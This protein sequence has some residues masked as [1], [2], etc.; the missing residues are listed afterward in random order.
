M[1]VRRIAALAGIASV[2]VA[3]L[4][5]ALSLM[6]AAAASASVSIVAN[7]TSGCTSAYCYQPASITINSG[8]SV[9]LTDNSIAPHTVTR[10][11]AAPGQSDA[12]CPAIGAAGN[13]GASN[14]KFNSPTL[15]ANGGTYSHTF[16]AVGSY[17][18]YCTIHGYSVMHATV[19]ANAAAATPGASP[20]AA[21]APA[22]A[23]PSLARAG[24]GPAARPPGIWLPSVAAA[25]VL[26]GL[27]TML[28]SAVA[29]KRRRR[30]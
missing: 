10:C 12:G 15:S 20:S 27:G 26:L 14:D 3:I 11:G 28:A 7:G 1:S 16:T 13:D 4:S 30:R 23:P 24:A 18:Y 29:A 9:N 2:V 6:P 22:T 21:L 25:F 19:T 8:D 17:T 5:G